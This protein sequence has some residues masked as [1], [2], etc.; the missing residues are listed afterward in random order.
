MNGLE[1]FFYIII[2]IILVRIENTLENT[3]AKIVY[4]LKKLKEDDNA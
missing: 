2:I 1:I 4:Q 3:S